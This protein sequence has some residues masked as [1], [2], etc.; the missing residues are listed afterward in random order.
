M[1]GGAESDSDAYSYNIITKTTQ[2][3]KKPTKVIPPSIL[4]LVSE[5]KCDAAARSV[6]RGAERTA[7]PADGADAM[8]A[9]AMSAAS[10]ND[11]GC[12]TRVPPSYHL[13]TTFF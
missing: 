4:E 11:P 9:D 12:T 3:T 2:H 7:M 13:R 8:S 6:A 1:F 10:G 5:K